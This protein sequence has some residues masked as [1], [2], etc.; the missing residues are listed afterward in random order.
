MEAKRRYG[1]AA[2]LEG[3]ATVCRGCGQ[4]VIHPGPHPGA[5]W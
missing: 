2:V 1:A 3:A 4:V 5:Q